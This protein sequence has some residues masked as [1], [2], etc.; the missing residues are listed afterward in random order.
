MTTALAQMIEAQP[1][2]L[3]TIAALDVTAAAGTLAGARRVWLIGTGTSHHA[4]E[5]GAT[6]LRGL[7]LDARAEAAV[8]F[9]RQAGRL[10][11]P[12][13][14][15]ILITHTAQT[16]YAR[17][18]RSLLLAAAVPL[19]S[20]TG[21]AADWPEALRTPVTELS[22]TYT[23]SYTTALAVLARIAGELGTPDCGPAAVRAVADAVRAV[24]ADPRIDGVPRPGRAMAIVG[25]G[26]LSV[27][28]REGALKIREGARILCEGFDP[29]R[30][31]H[32]AAVPYGPG[33]TLLALR[34]EADP[35]GLTGALAEAA[36]AEGVQVAVLDDQATAAAPLLDQIP[37]TV[38][39]Q[40]LADRFARER[41]QNPDVAIVGA[42][43]APRL[44][45]LGG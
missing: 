1:A 21:P 23:V 14:A 37:V 34:P 13:D 45:E 38:R 33:D 32:G 39:L 18:S 31:L 17:R 27:T 9:A 24:L 10:L 26:D 25:A 7:G 12:G 11:H 20:V 15:A 35:D 41:A 44:W 4:A 29:E 28:A 36:A 30:L 8:S 2:A 3:D 6:A 16:A 5:L 22:E 42:W 40:K 19:I 43:A